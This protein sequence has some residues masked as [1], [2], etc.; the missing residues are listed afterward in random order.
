MID[1]DIGT[2]IGDYDGYMLM[3]FTSSY[4]FQQCFLDGKLFFNTAD[5]FA[6]CDEKGRGD[7]N[8]GKTF[9]INHKNPGLISVNLEVVNGHYMIV[10]RDYSKNPSDYIPGTIWDYSSSINRNR[11]IISLYMVYLNLN[12][13]IV[14]DFPD[15]MSEE[16]GEYGI[17]IL[18]RQKFFERVS[19]AVKKVEKCLEAKMGFVEY[20][21]ME[22][23]F[24]EWH[25]FK[26][27]VDKFGYQNEFRITFVNDKSEAYMLDL[28]CTLRDIAVPIMAKD[29]S[30]IHFDGENVLYPRYKKKLCLKLKTVHKKCKNA[31]Y[32][33]KNRII[34]AL[35]KH[36]KK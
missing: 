1:I 11:K 3:K 26:K 29:V 8:E 17:L 35:K 31:I 25:P 30:K 15:N 32:H 5:F 2:G 18:N 34:C 13:K 36:Q 33:Y 19:E 23:G 6:R 12:K 24:N 21:K 4:E 27:D 28:G 22:Q 16:F 10:E 14:S 9:V 20:H 7:N